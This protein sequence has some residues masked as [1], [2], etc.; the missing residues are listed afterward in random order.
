V[1]LK[2]HLAKKAGIRYFANHLTVSGMLDK[3]SNPYADRV[4][5][6]Q[7]NQNGRVLQPKVIVVKDNPGFA[8]AWEVN[9]FRLQEPNRRNPFDYEERQLL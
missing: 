5:S 8:P 2:P 1:L 6:R 3:S 4:I 7:F 9:A